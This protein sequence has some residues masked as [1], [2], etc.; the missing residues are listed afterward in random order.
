VLYKEVVVGLQESHG[1]TLL[2]RWRYRPGWALA[3]FTIRLQASRSLAL[4]FHS[5]IPIFLRSVD[6][7]SSHLI[8]GL[9]FRLDAYSFPYSIFFWGGI[10]VSCILSI[11]PSYHILWHLIN[12][13]MFSSL[14]MASNLSFR[15]ILHNSFSF[16]GLYIFCKIFFS[17]TAN[18]F[19]FHG[20]CPRFWTI[21]DHWAYQCAVHPQ[22]A[23]SWYEAAVN[24]LSICIVGLT[25]HHNSLFY[26]FVITVSVTSDISQVLEALNCFECF[27]SN[28]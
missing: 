25:A 8:F 11:W 20:E 14:I 15:R 7:S 3:S 22:L 26:A 23:V 4:P 12:L 16:T 2:L 24:Q 1:R 27:I 19:L 18:V 13:T 5:F 28:S 10:A 21:G 17:N 6:T 9:P